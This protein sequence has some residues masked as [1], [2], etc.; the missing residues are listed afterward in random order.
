MKL[1]LKK[2]TV[3]NFSIQFEKKQTNYRKGVVTSEL[4]ET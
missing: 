2:Q 1:V 3:T 4:N